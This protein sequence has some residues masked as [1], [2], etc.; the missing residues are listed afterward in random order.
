MRYEDWDI[1]VGEHMKKKRIIVTCIILVLLCG[2]YLLKAIKPYFIAKNTSPSFQDSFSMEELQ[3]TEVS[4]QRVRLVESAEDGLLIRMQLLSEA[5][6]SLDI[7]YYTV[8]DGESTDIILGGIL[9]AADRGVRVRILLDGM[10]G[11]LDQDDAAVLGSHPNITLKYYNPVDLW[12]PERLNARLHDKYILADNRFLLLGGTNLGDIYMASVEYTGA[13]S[14]DRDVLVYN[15]R[16]EFPSESGVIS[17]V[18]AYLERLWTAPYVSEAKWKETSGMAGERHR[19]ISAAETYALNHDVQRKDERFYE[20]L[21]LPAA[22]ITLLCGD[23][24]P[25]PKAPEIGYALSRI[26]LEAEESVYLQSPYVILD[27]NLMAALEEL[28]EK[29]T[30]CT[31]LTNSIAAS[32]NPFARSAYQKDRKILGNMGFRLWEYQGPGSIHAKTYVTD[33][34]MVMTGSF[35]MD[36]RSAYIDTELMLVIDSPE[37]AEQV[38]RVQDV[39]RERALEVGSGGAYIE[40]PAQNPAKVGW[41]KALATSVLS[42]LADWIRFLV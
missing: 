26:V 23:T 40:N 35:N 24:E 15:T 11:K 1:L 32:P 33:R 28:A 3:G 17:D 14:Y 39:Y 19:L 16:W 30:D 5:R 12:K 37:L 41:L 38:L 8:H 10:F 20:E 2:C 29:D 34:R 18:R 7:S 13:R 21:T 25:G 42:P 36:P 22:R 27:Q 9:Q 6:E 4:C 31:I